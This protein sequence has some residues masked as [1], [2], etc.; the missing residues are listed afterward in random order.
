LVP[1]RPAV[2]KKGGKQRQGRG[3]SR[4]ELAKAGVSFQDARRFGIAVDRR[5]KSAHDENVEAV[6]SLVPQ[7]KPALK[8]AVKT[9]RKS[10]S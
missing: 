8:K 2:Q 9:R 7:R 6:K 3:F 10:K 4:E 1:T 5:R